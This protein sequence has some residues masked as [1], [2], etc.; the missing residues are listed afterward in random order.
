MWITL[1]VHAFKE[2]LRKFIMASVLLLPV[3]TMI[4]VVTDGLHDHHAL[5]GLWLSYFCVCMTWAI[6]HYV[7]QMDAGMHPEA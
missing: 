2:V 3:M 1:V 5:A 4:D 7:W 6:A